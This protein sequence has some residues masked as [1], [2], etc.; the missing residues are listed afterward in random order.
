MSWRGPNTCRI[1][2]ACRE[3]SKNLNK[4][5]VSKNLGNRYYALTL[6][7]KAIVVT[8]LKS[9]KGPKSSASYRPFS[10]TSTMAKSMER[11]INNRL[12][13]LL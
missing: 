10:L 2:K 5:V 6:E 12:N 4:Y 8:V 9:G 13:W 1:L 3:R 7:K 11:I